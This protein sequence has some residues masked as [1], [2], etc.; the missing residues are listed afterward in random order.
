M[1]KYCFTICIVCSLVH[2]TLASTE[3][4]SAD[5][6]KKI[7][8]DTYNLQLLQGNSK[9]LGLNYKISRFLYNQEDLGPYLDKCALDSLSRLK[10]P[11]AFFWS[12]K[13]NLVPGMDHYL[14]LPGNYLCSDFIAA[15]LVYYWIVEIN[16]DKIVLIDNGQCDEIKILHSKTNGYR[17]LICYQSYTSPGDELQVRNFIGGLYKAKKSNK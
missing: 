17:D 6:Y 8:G 3:T 2:P 12:K 15:H 13:V 14:V 1:K 16:N 7:N 10:Y 9:F 4:Y 5:K 11:E